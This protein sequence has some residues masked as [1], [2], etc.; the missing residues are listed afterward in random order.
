M[1]KDSCV[2]ALYAL[3]QCEVTNIKDVRN[4]KL[5]LETSDTFLSK[6]CSILD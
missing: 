5:E 1:L 3:G 6:F 2:T 4:R